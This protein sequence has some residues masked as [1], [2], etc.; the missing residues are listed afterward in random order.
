[1]T[2]DRKITVDGFRPDVYSPTF[3]CRRDFSFK[4]LCLSS[5]DRNDGE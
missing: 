3:F 2:D 1:M 5:L 4:N